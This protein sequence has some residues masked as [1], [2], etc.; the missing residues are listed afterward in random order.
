MR[1]P[2]SPPQSDNPFKFSM[3]RNRAGPE[4]FLKSRLTAFILNNILASMSSDRSNLT[5][6]SP[7][8]PPWF[9]NPES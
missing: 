9:L 1:A 2:R 7:R 5:S 8:T 3:M 6:T 4:S